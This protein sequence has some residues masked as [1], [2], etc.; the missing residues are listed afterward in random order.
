MES[1]LFREKFI[2]WPDKSRLIG[3]VGVVGLVIYFYIT[4]CVYILVEIKLHIILPHPQG[5]L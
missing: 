3:T 5:F 4:S 1:I 2:D